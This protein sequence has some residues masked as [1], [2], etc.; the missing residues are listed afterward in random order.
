M[1]CIFLSFSNFSPWLLLIYLFCMVP[2]GKSPKQV[3]GVSVSKCE[4]IFSFTLKQDGVE[5]CCCCFSCFQFTTGF[6][7]L[8]SNINK[9]DFPR[10]LCLA[11]WSVS[12]YS[13]LSLTS[14]FCRLFVTTRWQKWLF[15]VVSP[16]PPGNKGSLDSF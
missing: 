15:F 16:V 9:P 4:Y 1:F 5:L 12:F 11:A 8:T 6:A 10:L 3:N 13:L 2:Y 7:S 14:F